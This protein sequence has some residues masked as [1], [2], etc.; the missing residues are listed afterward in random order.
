MVM[1]RRL[2][3]VWL[4]MRYPAL[5]L[6]CLFVLLPIA[7]YAQPDT[8]IPVPPANWYASVTG[9]IAVTIAITSGLKRLIGNVKSLNAIPTWV[10]VVAIAEILTFICVQV[11]KTMPGPLGQML[12][13]AL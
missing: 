13:Q 1:K 9:I 12:Y 11:F 3:F 10:Y 4:V 7:V 8:P 2:H 5:F 6:S